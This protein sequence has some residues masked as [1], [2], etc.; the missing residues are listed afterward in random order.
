[1]AGLPWLPLRDGRPISL[2][3]ID[4]WVAKGLRGARL[5]TVRVGGALATTES[6]LMTFFEALGDSVVTGPTR[7]NVNDFRALLIC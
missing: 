6:W 2:A 5:R 3:T 4:R 1:M 7:T